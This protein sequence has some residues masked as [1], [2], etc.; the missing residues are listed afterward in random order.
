MRQLT[1]WLLLITSATFTHLSFAKDTLRIGLS[2]HYA[3]LAFKQ[4]GQLTGIEVAAGAAIAQQLGRQPEFV[5]L[6]FNQLIPALQAGKIDIIMSGMSITPERS[7]LVDFSSSYLSAGQMAIIRYNDAGRFAYKGMLFRPNTRVAVVKGTTGDNFASNNLRD[8]VVSRCDSINEALAKLKSGSV[9]FVIHDAAT[10]WS[11]ATDT[12]RQEF[13]SLNNE[14]TEENL[15]WA[16]NKG[17]NVLLQAV[18]QQLAIMQRNGMLRAII[19]KW[20]PV[21]VEV[22][23]ATST[24]LSD[25]SP[26]SSNRGNR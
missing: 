5:E 19:N 23:A 7:K 15:G 26:S 17:N 20:I 3:P 22:D 4:D 12:S 16:V 14:L 10:S 25:T 6:E 18:N 1:L 8:A 13:M 9:D 11:L 21:T 2:P 24:H